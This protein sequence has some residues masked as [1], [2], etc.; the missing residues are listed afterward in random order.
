MIAQAPK[1][2]DA[3]TMRSF[4]WSALIIAVL[5]SVFFVTKHRADLFGTAIFETGD[6]A[7][8]ALQINRAAECKEIYGNYSRWGFNHPGPAFFYI[9]AWGEVIFHQLIHFTKSPH[10]SHALSSI[11][12]QSAL[13]ALGLASL[14]KLFNVRL[15]LFFA[16]IALVHLS[17]A[18][19]SAAC[20]W[21]P[22]SLVG[23]TFAFYP[24]AAL[25]SLGN[26][27][28]LPILVL[29]GGFL[30][31]AHV[32]QPLFVGPIALFAVCC[33]VLNIQRGTLK[34]NIFWPVVWS[35]LAASLFAL[36]L[37]LDALKLQDSN[38]ASIIAHLE[39]SSADGKSLIQSLVY[40]GSFFVY[41]PNPETIVSNL[42]W[43]EFWHL[44]RQ[45]SLVVCTM[46][47]FLSVSSY[48]ASVQRPS[49]RRF[50]LFTLA[51]VILSVKWG[52]MQSGEMY[53]FN[54]YFFYSLILL[55]FAP[56]CFLMEAKLA[57]FASFIRNSVVSALTLLALAV[58]VQV[59]CFIQSSDMV[60]VVLKESKLDMH[61]GAFV[62]L[63]FRHANWPMAAAVALQLDRANV[64]FLVDK[65]WKF[66]FGER[67]LAAR[68][69]N[70]AGQV[71]HIDSAADP[72]GRVHPVLNCQTVLLPVISFSFDSS[73]LSFVGWSQVEP[74]H[75]WSV[76]SSSSVSFNISSENQ[77]ARRLI[78]KGWSFGA[79][80]IAIF[81]NGQK[82]H[83]AILTGAPESVAINLPADLLEIGDN[84]LQFELPDA[85]V[86]DNGDPRTLGFA[87]E[88]IAFE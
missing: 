52:M 27:S 13:F 9:Y 82:I 75:R 4:W 65:K 15:P 20:V 41:Y 42:K 1:S 12:L 68:N 78:L 67:H 84:T 69:G 31:H 10:Q 74:T 43:S 63:D 36:P 25:V 72:T 16:S 59:P 73:Q 76:G 5:F 40:L 48:S 29:V 58:P 57:K 22:S 49:V 6:F 38:I 88:S 2:T 23:P 60:P 81:L 46:V 24:I 83:D 62:H 80:R 7:V 54:T 79:Q 17:L 45:S 8:N 71:L 34:A 19:R 44:C 64:K 85:R 11:I 77:E 51:G 32:A 66:M 47:M 26:I 3:E 35:I 21:A 50:I 56:A 33:L 37:I 30:L 86:P 55:L 61:E 87:L 39:K 28:L 70:R 53:A 14:G 18:D